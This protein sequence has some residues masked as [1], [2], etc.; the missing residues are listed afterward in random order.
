MAKDVGSEGSPRTPWL[1]WRW[2][3]DTY[4]ELWDS[5]VWERRI[6]HHPHHSAQVCGG[7]QGLPRQQGSNAI[8]ALASRATAPCHVFLW[9][10]FNSSSFSWNGSA[11]KS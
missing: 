8:F 1:G 11:G 10:C 7:A 3:P 2:T 5:G 6:T 4:K 9:Y